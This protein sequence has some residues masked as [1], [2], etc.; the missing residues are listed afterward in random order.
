MRNAA[1]ASLHYLASRKVCTSKR[2]KSS[3]CEL[4]NLH[5]IRVKGAEAPGGKNEY[6]T[7]M[8]TY[9]MVSNLETATGKCLQGRWK[10]LCYALKYGNDVF[11]FL[12]SLIKKGLQWDIWRGGTFYCWAISVTDTLLGLVSTKYTNKP[13][14]YSVANSKYKK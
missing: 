14:E 13:D 7:L 5:R 1:F 10:H 11:A 2:W 9:S 12:S 8:Q 3:V 4:N 6:D